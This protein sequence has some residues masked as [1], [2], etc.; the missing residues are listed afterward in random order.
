MPPRRPVAAR[1]LEVA[2]LAA[3]LAVIIAVCRVLGNLLGI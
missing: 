2:S 3:V 1:L